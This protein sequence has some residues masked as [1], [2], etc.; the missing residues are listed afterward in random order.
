MALWKSHVPEAVGLLL[1]ARLGFVAAAPEPNT[2]HLPR[3]PEGTVVPRDVA[4]QYGQLFRLFRRYAD[5]MERVSFWNLRD[6]QSW[7]NG[8]PWRRASPAGL[9]GGDRSPGGLVPARK[10]TPTFQRSA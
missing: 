4:W 10:G 3:A 8:F 7:L 1:A 2:A 9:R 6:G 5:V